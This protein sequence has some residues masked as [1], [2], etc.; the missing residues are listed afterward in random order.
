MRDALAG[1]WHIAFPPQALCY[2]CPRWSD[3]DLEF[4]ACMG[5]ASW[6]KQ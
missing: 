3:E 4:S 5:F 6:T 1:A 2:F